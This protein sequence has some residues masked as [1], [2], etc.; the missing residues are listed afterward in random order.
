MSRRVLIVDDDSRFRELVRMLLDG[1]SD[2]E[3]VGEAP[4]GGAGVE[5]A[6]DLGP[7]VVLLDVNLP[8]ANGFDLVPKITEAGDDPAVVIISS[9]DDS[10]Y[11][12][13][14]EGAG[15]RGFVSKHELTLDALRELLPAVG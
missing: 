10:S 13:L 4:E 5:A 15:A 3:V 6:R 2:F 14:A 11:A 1:A 9:R 12:Q 8:D 7:D